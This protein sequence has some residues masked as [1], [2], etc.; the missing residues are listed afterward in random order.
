MTAFA[1][2]RRTLTAKGKS[3]F[4][5]TSISFPVIPF[6]TKINA[7]FKSFKCT[8]LLHGYHTI[9][10]SYSHHCKEM[11]SLINTFVLLKA[12]WSICL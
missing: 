2:E 11:L 1:L 12:Y 8:L 3:A 7:N 9:T 4:K 6:E 10:T 5:K